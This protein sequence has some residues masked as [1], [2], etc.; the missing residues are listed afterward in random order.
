MKKYLV[1]LVAMLL[2]VTGCGGKKLTCTM[3]EDGQTAKTV[4]EFDKNDKA[5]KVNMTMTMPFEEELSKEEMEYMESYMGLMCA[6]F[7]YEGVTCKTD[8]SSKKV[9]VVIDMDFGKMSKE[10]LAELDF[11]AE[12]TSYDAMKKSLEESGYT[13]K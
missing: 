5:K 8:M 13:C 12:A 10:T 9:D 4:V 7:D 6:A 2:V 1:V 11:D 3:E